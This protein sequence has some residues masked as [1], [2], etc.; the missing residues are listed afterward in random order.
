MMVNQRCD[1]CGNQLKILENTDGDYYV[2]EC[3]CGMK[4]NPEGKIKRKCKHE[5]RQRLTAQYQNESSSDFN[6]V[7]TEDG[8]YCV[9][10]REISE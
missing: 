4:K 9:H 1:S 8:Y 6:K 2:Q 7:L 3:I 10:C 5:W